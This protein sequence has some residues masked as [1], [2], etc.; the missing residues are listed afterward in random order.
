MPA[1]LIPAYPVIPT[2]ESILT[3]VD[4]GAGYN[5]RS[6]VLYLHDYTPFRT[7]IL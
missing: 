5:F 4:C 7:I 3:G 2:G 6:S 1:F